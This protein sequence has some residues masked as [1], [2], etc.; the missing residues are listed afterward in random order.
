MKK[1]LVILLI[2]AVGSII[3]IACGVNPF[4]AISFGLL[5]AFLIYGLWNPPRKYK[6]YSLTDQQ[7]AA[8]RAL[9]GHRLPDASDIKPPLKN[10]NGQ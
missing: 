1:T 9:G 2:T 6:T 3:L 4:P 7:E 10:K 5:I 8:H